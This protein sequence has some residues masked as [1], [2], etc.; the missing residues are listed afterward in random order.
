[1][2]SGLSGFAPPSAPGT[3]DLIARRPPLSRHRPENLRAVA[4]SRPQ[5]VLA[6]RPQSIRDGAKLWEIAFDEHSPSS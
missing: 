6:S 1:M 2:R 3:A 4:F 5:R